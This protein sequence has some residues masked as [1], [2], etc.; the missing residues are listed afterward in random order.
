M[1]KILNKKT[2]EIS[3][4]EIESIYDLFE[5]VF[6]KRR[7]IKDFKDQFL[8]TSLGYSFHSIA[9]DDGK[10]VGHNVY[11][12]FGYLKDSTPFIACLSV[13]AMIH[14]DYRGKGLYRKLLLGCEELA[15]SEGCR[16]RIGFPND[17]SYPVQING[18]KYNDVGRLD[19]FCLPIKIGEFS[20][21]L[22]LFNFATR[23]CAS[24]LTNI[25]KLSSSSSLHEYKY[26]KDLNSFDSYR[27]KW[28][29]GDYKILNK[30]GVKIIYKDSDFKGKKAT[31]ILDVQPMNKRNFDMAVRE[32]YKN[33]KSYSPFILYVGNLHFSPLSMIRIPAKF[34]PKHFHFVTKILDPAFIGGDSLDIKNWELNLSNYDLL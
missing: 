21:K 13:D 28:F 24:I 15:K 27:Y 30:D 32:V 2:S 6:H 17:N 16:I 31:F 33:V 11:V 23:I 22:K 10:V 4:S 12:P 1:L 14:P 20:D 18:F 9:V 5:E 26:R 7:I 29:D 34:E 8:N 19:T 25:S 3:D